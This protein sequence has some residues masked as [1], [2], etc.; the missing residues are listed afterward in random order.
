MKR[1]DHARHD[2]QPLEQEFPN[3]AIPDQQLRPRREIRRQWRTPFEEV[4][5]GVIASQERN[6]LPQE[7]EIRIVDLGA[8][9]KNQNDGGEKSHPDEHGTVRDLIGTVGCL[10]GLRCGATAHRRPHRARLRELL[11]KAREF[12]RAEPPS[13]L[14]SLVD[15]DSTVAALDFE[16]VLHEV[17]AD[18]R[19]S[20][21]IVQNRIVSRD[22]E[23]NRLTLEQRERLLVV[24]G[25]R[26]PPGIPIQVAASDRALGVVAD[27]ERSLPSNEQAVSRS[28]A[29]VEIAKL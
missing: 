12:A 4:A 16:V 14:P 27:I 2:E 1:D 21:Q 20:L 9:G 26:A 6:R 18:F 15:E 5:I 3:E 28:C 11:A 17:V 25:A 10:R 29:L 8:G 22:R 19:I 23:G 24:R 7:D 13:G